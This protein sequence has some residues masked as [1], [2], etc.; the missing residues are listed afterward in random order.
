MKKVFKRRVDTKDRKKIKDR[1]QPLPYPEYDY[2]LNLVNE[3]RQDGFSFLVLGDAGSKGSR[4]RIKYDVAD[5]MAEEENID[6]ILH[7]GDVVYLSGS[8]EGYKDR[9]IKAYHHW[10]LN[11]ENHKYKNMVFTKPFLPVYG[12]HDYFDLANAIPI[13]IIGKILGRLIGEVLDEVGTGSKNGRVFER[14]FV[15]SK[16]SK[17]KDGALPYE[18]GTNTRV[19]NRYYWFTHGPCAFYALDS[20]TLDCIKDP[21]VKRREELTLRL[22]SARNR[23]DMRRNQYELLRRHI[24]EGGVQENIEGISLEEVEATLY[25]IVIDLSDAEQDIAMLEKYLNARRKDYDRAQLKWFTKVLKH[26]DAQGKWKIVFMHHPLYSSD[27]SHT[28]D[29]ESEGLREN[30][31]A[32]LV[33]N[34]VHLVISGHSHC[35]EWLKRA[36]PAEGENDPL[37]VLEQ[38][39]CYLV[40]GGGGRELRKSILE[41]DPKNLDVL[42]K[43]GQFLKVAESGAYTAI[44]DGSPADHIYHYMRID[45]DESQLKIMPVGVVDRGKEKAIREAPVRAKVFTKTEDGISSEEKRLVGVN[46]FRDRQPTAEWGSL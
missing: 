34:G 22:Q 16:L 5:Y 20:N 9:F 30:L 31:R 28:D 44:G 6:L 7:T 3:T 10:L 27:G 38:K 19:P 46:V 18:T 45:V 11:G 12:N 15:S 43:R 26:E 21:T 17:L 14:A 1:T 23:A 25:E 33:E 4:H 2:R 24:D 41:E 42:L 32:L 40:S 36:L 13:P 37:A 29:P 35:F 8:K 39:I